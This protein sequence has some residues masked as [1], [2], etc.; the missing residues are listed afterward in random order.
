MHLTWPPDEAAALNGSRDDGK[1]A[2][3]GSGQGRFDVVV[4]GGGQAALATAWFLRRTGL[5][6]LLLDA[7]E[8][9]G[10]AWRHG[11]DSLR[12]FSP[13]EWSSIPG[14]QMPQRSGYPTRDE[15][16]DYLTEYERRY[17][18]PVVRP[19]RVDRVQA[20]GQGF[21]L[22]TNRGE[23][24]ARSVISATGTWRSPHVPAFDGADAYSGQQLHSARYV[25]AAPFAGKRV[26]VIGGGNSG[27]QVMA[28]VSAVARATWVTLESPMFLP[29]EVDGRV[30]FARATERWRAQQE[31]REIEQPVGG[32]GDIVMVAPV[33]E[34]RDRD[35]LQSVR[36]FQ[37]FTTDGVVWPD[38]VEEPVDAVIWCT[39][40][41]PALQHLAPLDVIDAD[42]RV[43]VEGTRSVLQPML[44]L[45]GYGDWTGPAS[46]TLVGVTRTARSTVAELVATLTDPP[47]HPAA[48]AKP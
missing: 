29:D 7:E 12:L 22:H 10:G 44:W 5:S 35:A 3:G 24:F 32:L 9:P 6:F 15:V 39:G 11:W 8:G 34:A 28:E 36:P 45:V 14:W 27:A 43:A 30:L 31:G 40:F 17:A 16:I 33:R 1:A 13:A 26:L 2:P 37:R 25:N 48:E 47:I 21:T 42:G 4:V 23:F 46:A 38:G 19:C 41:R 20:D 18:L